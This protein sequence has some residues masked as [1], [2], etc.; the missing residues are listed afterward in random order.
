VVLFQGGDAEIRASLEP[1]APL[2]A[3]ADAVFVTPLTRFSNA[4]F[5]QLAA[6]LNAKRLPTFTSL[7]RPEVEA[8]MLMAS[9]GSAADMQRLARR[10]VL[11]VQRIHAG[12]DAGTFEVGFPIQRRLLLNMRTARAIGFSPRWE[13]L[14]DAEQL[15]AEPPGGAAPP[16]SMLAAMEAAITANP[17]LAAA[18][19]NVDIANDDVRSA[20]ANLLPQVD[21]AASDTRIDSDRASP[22][23]QAEQTFSGSVS[24]TQLVYSDQAWAGYTISKRLAAAELAGY[25]TSMLDTLQSAAIAYLDLLRAQSVEAVRRANVEN[26][27]RNFETS[28]VREAVGLAERS[29]YLR[30]VSQLA[31]DRSN[32]LEA[33][34]N[35]LQAQTQLARILHRPAAQRIVTVD[36]S[37]DEPLGFVADARTQAFLDTPAK[38]AIFT[39]HSVAAARRRAPEIEQVDLQIAAQ[40]RSVSAARRA[41]YLPDFALV[42][43]G[44]EAFQR[45]GVGSQSVPGAPDEESWNISLQA[46]LPVFTGGANRAALSRAR[47]GTASC[48]T[49]W[50]SCAP[51]CCACRR[52]ARSISSARRM[53]SSIST[54]RRAR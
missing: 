40:D 34:A 27:R 5:E 18:R 52:W 11:D 6:G 16:L 39:E 17:A 30:W 35:R 37:L 53:K 32:L 54:S 12:E 10:I 21:A 22:L 26:T 20:R 25:R 13:D 8:G 44:Q 7:G 28:R 29:D 48:A 38:W 33:E 31:R 3:D 14:I 23:L 41:S 4:Q 19:L 36:A 51:S 24:V 15:F 9:S 45:S 43:Q 50:S 2:P 42:S 1:L 49:T 47:H 46:S